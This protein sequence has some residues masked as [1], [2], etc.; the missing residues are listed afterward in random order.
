MRR[1]FAVYCVYIC[2]MALNGILEAFVQGL[3]NRA[4]EA[5]ITGWLYF[6]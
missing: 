1:F 4:A 3:P 2:T 5:T 6:Q